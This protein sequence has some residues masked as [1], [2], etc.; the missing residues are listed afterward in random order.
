[1]NWKLFTGIG[2]SRVAGI[3]G[4]AT[5]QSS[6]YDSGH[7]LSIAGSRRPSAGFTLVELMVAIT[8]YLIVV[9]GI[10]ALL[11]TVIKGFTS[12]EATNGLKKN[13]QE[14]INR[15]YLAL[16]EN[17]RIFQ[18]TTADNAFLSKVSLSGAPA[19][20][21]GSKLPK[22]EQNGTLFPATT[23]F[24]AGSVG[25]CLFFATNDPTQ[26]LTG[27]AGSSGSTT[28]VRTDIY[29]FN[30]YYLSTVNPKSIT[31]NVSYSLVEWVSVAYADY[32]QLLSITDTTLRSNSVKRLV[33]NGL[34]FA[35]DP[36]STSATGAFYNLGSG[37]TISLSS[38]HSIQKSRSA[39]L[40]KILTGI[41][42]RGYKYGVSPN[43]YGWPKAPVTVP[44]YATASGSFPGGFEIV[45][46]GS[47]MGR[48]VLVRIVIVAQ[49]AMAK[50]LGNDQTIVCSAHDVW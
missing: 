10:T 16:I 13:N 37:G 36:T 8:I 19:V 24:V 2:S 26:I 7:A 28:T 15:V 5:G 20:L 35:W 47:S 32:N 1:M 34:S 18:N 44:K 4:A 23:N 43:S 17:K 50:I 12:Y 46:V 11:I 6:S 49:G 3:K 14:S 38:G 48:R 22:V 21:T 31:G 9:P 30:Y 27:V 42:G 25:N 33:A 29:R 41:M 45:V 39:V 40:T